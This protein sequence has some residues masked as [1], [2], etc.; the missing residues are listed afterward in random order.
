VLTP[1]Q[2]GSIA[3]AAIVVAAVKLGIG[4][5][6]PVNEGLRYDLIFDL[7]C[8]KR[9]QCKWATLANEVIYIRSYSCRRT[10][11]GLLRRV[12]VD[13]EIDAIAAYCAEIDRCYFIPFERLSTHAAIQL[14]LGPTKNNQ[15]VGVNWASEYEFT[16]TLGAVQGP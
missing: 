4:V 5:S 10:R 7:G 9:V 2:K 1:S 13:G 11:D 14:R 8:L 16:A 12:Y 6:K 3:E 15:H